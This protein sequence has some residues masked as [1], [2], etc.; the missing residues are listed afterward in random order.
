[1]TIVQTN[2]DALL[3]VFIAPAR[4]KK[5]QSFGP[6]EAVWTEGM[7]ESQKAQ[8]EFETSFSAAG[9]L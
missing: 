9:L 6:S 3:I 7:H 4:V 1:V 2:L 5:R 8:Q